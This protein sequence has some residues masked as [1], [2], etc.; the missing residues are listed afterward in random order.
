MIKKLITIV[1]VLLS[2][3]ST[4][5]FADNTGSFTGNINLLEKKVDVALK[6]SD[7]SVFQAELLKNPENKF[8][9]TGKVDHLKIPQFDISTIFEGLIDINTDE[10]GT[11]KGSFKSSYSLI[12]YKP[13]GALAGQFE[14]KGGRLFL[15]SVFWEEM[16]LDGSLSLLAPYDVDVSVRLS[17]VSLEELSSAAS[18]SGDRPFKG[19]VSGVV[20]LTGSMDQ[21]FLKGRL[22]ASDGT[23]QDFEYD[24]LAVN[25][26]GAYPTLHISDSQVTQTDGLTFNMDGNIN[27]DNPYDLLGEMFALKLS[28]LIAETATHREW[29]IKR[30]ED[31]NTSSISE[32]RYR[33]SSESQ[34]VS[35]PKQE[36][37]L[38]VEQSIRF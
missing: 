10:N 19:L 1:S 36:G 15:E 3:A 38:G 24:K 9:L 6:L 37:I 29:T 18:S 17:H 8:Y 12:N 35:S 22:E 11:I 21:P 14:I 20:H 33:M 5:A 31:K 30:K 26:E 25:F 34:D 16:M 2:V 4:A 13:V 23:I 32:L 28:P 7:G 27:I